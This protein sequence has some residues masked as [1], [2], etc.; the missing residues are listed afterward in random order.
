MAEYSSP[1]TIVLLSSISKP[2]QGLGLNSKIGKQVS[3]ILYKTSRSILVPMHI[4]TSNY[5]Q[6]QVKRKLFLIK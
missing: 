5:Q 3:E 1:V 2:D 6:V 4:F